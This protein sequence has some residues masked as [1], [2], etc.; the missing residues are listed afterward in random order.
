MSDERDILLRIV[1]RRID[2][3]A[4]K[5]TEVLLD[6]ENRLTVEQIENKLGELGH[7]LDQKS[8]RQALYAMNDH[9]FARSR[10]TRDS[11][12]GWINFYW[13]LFP[14]KILNS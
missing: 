9:G 8:I 2:A 7:P 11:E 4:R 3:D 5:V 13:N 6:A 10:R 14:D 12:T 1:E